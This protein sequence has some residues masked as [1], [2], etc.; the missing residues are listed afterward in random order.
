VN[1]LV[2][3]LRRR[4]DAEPASPVITFLDGEGGSETITYAELDRRAR[5]VA[6]LIRAADRHRRR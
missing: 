2:E 3:M 4:A 5:G 6:G 1:T